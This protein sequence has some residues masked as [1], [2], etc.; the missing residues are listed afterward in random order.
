MIFITVIKDRSVEGEGGGLSSI[1]GG[2]GFGE[3]L[4]GLGV[5]VPFVENAGLGSD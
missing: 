2:L 1:L 3:M 5:L 4:G